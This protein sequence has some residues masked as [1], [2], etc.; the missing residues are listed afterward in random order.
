MK[1][2]MAISS[3]PQMIQLLSN[4]HPS[5]EDLAHDA[6]LLAKKFTWTN[7]AKILLDTLG[8]VYFDPNERYVQPYT[9]EES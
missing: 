9:E 5:E 4:S 8:A 1:G 3:I 7:T 6:K 2:S